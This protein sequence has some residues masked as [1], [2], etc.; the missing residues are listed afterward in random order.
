MSWHFSQAL[1]AEFL[2]ERSLD[3]EPSAPWRS[4]PIAAND[5]C[6]AKMKDIC[7]RSPFGMMFVPLTDANGTA[8]LTSFLEASHAK[9]SARLE[10]VQESTESD[11][12]CGASLHGLFAR[13]DRVS[14]LWRTPQTSLVEG[15]DVFSATWPRWGTMRNGA[16]WERPTLELHTNEIE[17]GSLL[18]TLTASAYGTNQGGA[19]G[20]V[21]KVRPSLQTMAAKGLLPTLTVFG[22]YNRK[23]VSPQS[24]DGLATA[25]AKLPTLRRTDGDRGGRGDPIQALRGNQNSHFKMP[26]LQARDWKGSSGR[27]MKG[28][29][30]DLPTAVRM[31][32]TLTARCAKETTFCQSEMARNSPNLAATIMSEDQSNGGPLNPEWCEWFMGWPIGWTASA[33]LETVRFQQWL[34]SHGRR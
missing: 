33:P 27:S 25:I 19:A 9:T 20:R 24:G 26:T 6:S 29:E 5:S 1:E 2:G 18:P 32:P 30:C 13:F 14:R 23:G 3:G 34:H 10:K 22:N 31:M 4:M 11:R 28:E 21:G 16:C 12:D 7:H 17:S 8:L 15:L